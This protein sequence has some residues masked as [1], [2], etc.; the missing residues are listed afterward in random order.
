MITYNNL[1][2]AFEAFVAN[3]KMLTTFTHGDPTEVDI[4]K[5]ESYPLMHL[6]YTGSSYDTNTKRYSVE[7]YLLDVP[8]DDSDEAA[9]E[10]EAVSDAEQLA[11]DI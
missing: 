5:I 10:R 3:H 8:G 11:E 7:L 4:E 9:H 2:A 1:V 6:V